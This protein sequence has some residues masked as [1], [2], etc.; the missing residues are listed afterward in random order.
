MGTGEWRGK[1][2]RK[3]DELKIKDAR[4]ALDLLSFVSSLLTTQRKADREKVIDIVR[5]MKLE[6]NRYSSYLEGTND[7][8]DN[9]IQKL[10]TGI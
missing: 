3:L 10:D 7:A 5:G 8:L 6:D 9:L 1:F 4:T 2:G